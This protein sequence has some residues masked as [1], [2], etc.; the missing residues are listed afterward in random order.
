MIN[1]KNEV[2]PVKY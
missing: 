1:G 2:G